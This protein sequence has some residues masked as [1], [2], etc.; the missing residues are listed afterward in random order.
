[1]TETYKTPH[2]HTALAEILKAMSVEKGGLLPQN[3]GGKTYIQAHDL[4]AEAKRQFVANNLIAIPTEELLKHEIVLANNRTLVAT[5]IKAEYT[6]ISTVD[7]SSVTFTGIGD[8]LATGTAVSS[9]IASTNALKNGFL[10][11]FLITEQSVEEQAKRGVE[12]SG[13]DSRATQA[14]Q[15]AKPK[16][17]TATASDLDAL[18]KEVRE[19]WAELAPALGNGFNPQGYMDLGNEKFPGEKWASDSKRLRELIKSIKAGEVA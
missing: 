9:N 7:G 14:V 17:T 15:A 1:M 5:A 2:V 4:A 19:A 10:R 8:G 3:M 11:A 12:D 13:G 16:A 6:L 18:R